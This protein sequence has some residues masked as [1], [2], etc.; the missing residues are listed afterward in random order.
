M[1]PRSRRRRQTPDPGTPLI[2]AT[3]T[4]GKRRRHR[5]RIPCSHQE[6]PLDSPTPKRRKVGARR[7][8]LGLAFL[9]WLFVGTVTLDCALEFA[10]CMLAPSFPESPPQKSAI[11]SAG[12]RLSCPEPRRVAGRSRRIPLPKFTNS[13]SRATSIPTVLNSSSMNIFYPTRQLPIFRMQHIQIFALFIFLLATICPTLCAQSSNQAAWLR[14]A[15]LA[16]KDAAQYSLLPRRVVHLGDSPILDSAQR[17]LILGLHSM[18]NVEFTSASDP[19]SHNPSIILGTIE[20]VREIFPDKHPPENLP[21]D[22]YWISEIPGPHFSSILIA[23]KNDRGVLYGVFAVLSRIARAQSLNSFK[24]ESASPANSIRMIDQWDNLDGTIERGYAGPSIFFENGHVRADLSR[25]AEYSRLLASVGINTCAINNVNANPFLL[26]ESFLPQLRR[27]AE[28]FRPWGVHLALSVDVSSP[29]TIGGLESFDPLDPKIADWWQHKVNALYERIPDFAGFVVKADSEGRAGPN[30]YGRTPADAANVIAKALKPHNGYLFYRSFVY[31]HH[32]DWQNPKNDRAK[33][34]YD[35]FHPLDGQ[36]ADNV[37]IQ[38]KHGPIDFQVREPVSPLLGGL[39]QTN[40]AIE[41]QITQ[42][43]TG[44]QRHLCFLLPVWKQVLD[45]DMRNGG[46]TPVHDLV[47]GKIYERPVGG[48]VGVANVGM[49]PNWLAHPLAMANLYGFGRLA[50]DPTLSAESIAEEWTRLTFGN[51]EKTVSTVDAMLLSSWNIYESY[52]G[53]LGAGTLT[54]ILGS[55]YGPGVE[56]SER[57]GWG[58]WHRADQDGI[59]MDRTVATGTGYVTQYSRAAAKVYESLG[60]TPDELLLFFHHVPYSYKLHSGKTVIQ[61]IYD[62]HYEGASRAAELV[63][64]WQSLKGR[65]DAQRYEDVLQRLDYQAGHAVVWRDAICNW[66]AQTSG[67]PDARGRVGNHPGRVE[68]ESMNLQGYT[69]FDVTPREAA[70]QGK[71]VECLSTSQPVCSATMKFAGEAG[72]YDI[73][74]RYFDQSNGVSHFRVLLVNKLI[75]EWSA[76]QI[77]PCKIPNA[78]SSTRYRIHGITLKPGDEL[79]IEG[80]P[81]GPEHAAL[82]YVEFAPVKTIPQQ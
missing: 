65:V 71:A 11:L 37:V 66:F 18:L 74:I 42:E 50:W 33:A 69:P 73:D 79:R 1:A 77:Y 60:T 55:H 28:A 75:A 3:Q 49:D 38:I 36:F 82:D 24:G 70:S 76:D 53:P 43:Y 31:D 57:N 29:R 46:S 14:Y 58:Q 81:D 59:G 52:T 2:P 48:L 72:R 20:S 41:L 32:L 8:R 78:D 30:T 12:L 9:G 26:D 40:E 27:I 62:S 45:F 19:F 35:I 80:K 54:N 13:P 15:P 34:A 67:I 39:Q 22:A 44:Q 17:E 61:H 4:P 51:D 10:F 64:Q 56:S 63:D 16:A 47:S 25:A 5:P 6:S 68:A 21:E 23:G 7:A